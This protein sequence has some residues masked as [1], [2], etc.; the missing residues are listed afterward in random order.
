MKTLSSMLLTGALL[1][2]AGAAYSGDTKA[3]VKQESHNVGKTVLR[4]TS[5]VGKG[6]SKIYHDLASKTHKLIAKNRKNDHAKARH[7]T[8]SQIHRSHATRKAAQS[9]REM[10]KAEMHADRVGK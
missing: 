10:K 5:G 7:M 6:G 9:E 2:C 1:L 8:K 3:E 4:G